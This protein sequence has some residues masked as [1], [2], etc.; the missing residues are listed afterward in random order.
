MNLSLMASG[1]LLPVNSS[2][3][4]T[5]RS[6]DKICSSTAPHDADK[7]TL[8]RDAG[9]VCGAVDRELAQRIDFKKL[10]TRSRKWY[11]GREIQGQ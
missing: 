9:V 1:N 11:V 4:L 7:F 2:Y 3:E 5:R 8:I 10:E 6:P